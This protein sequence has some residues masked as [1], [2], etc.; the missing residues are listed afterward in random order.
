MPAS[1][2]PDD[3]QH[4][5][6]VLADTSMPSHSRRALLQR[7]AAGALAAGVASIAAPAALGASRTSN[8]DSVQSVLDTAITAEALAVAFLDELI[9]RLSTGGSL[10]GKP[11]SQSPLID[12]LR[13]AGAAEF[14]HFAALQ[15]LG[16]KPLATQVFIPDA[17]FG[18][19]GVKTFQNIELFE[20]L[21]VNAYLVAITVFGDA[22]QGKFARYAGEILG[23]EAEHRVL[24]RFAQNTIGPNTGH[25]ANDRAFEV[26]KFK[27]LTPI[28]QQIVGLGVGIGKQGK[29][30]GK[31]YSA[32]TKKPSTF[33]TIFG[34]KPD[35]VFPLANIK[36]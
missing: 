36:R 24:A 15:S 25:V 13:A 12:V 27:S 7:T 30:A 16:A 19:G 4:V 5:D 26:Y 28:V 8:A 34:N 35:P 1:L 18:D 3:L 10:A 23:T 20:A 29:G 6:N 31:T 9:K 14:D 17:L 22:N 11:A 21:F 2:T 33:S 32:L